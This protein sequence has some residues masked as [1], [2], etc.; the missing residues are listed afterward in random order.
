MKII[1]SVVL[2]N[3]RVTNNARSTRVTIRHT[4]STRIRIVIN[5]SDVR[6]CCR[7]KYAIINRH[8]CQ[9]L[10]QERRDRFF[11]GSDDRRT[12]EKAIGDR[13]TGQNGY[14]VETAA[15]SQP[16]SL[17]KDW[18]NFC[19]LILLYIIQG[20]PIGLC[21]AFPLILQNRMFTYEDQ[22]RKRK[23]YILIVDGYF[24]INV[25]T[26]CIKHTCGVKDFR[27]IGHR[28]SNRFFL[29]RPNKKMKY[30]PQNRRFIRDKFCNGN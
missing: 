23:Y 21:I 7:W 11:S 17:G 12:M 1:I 18:L 2:W 14:A 3:H 9:I 4:A 22:V 5:A 26:R 30:V 15:A 19:L 20:F 6:L 27:R 28:F 25:Q 29:L 16:P 10:L 24:L 13:K 8:P